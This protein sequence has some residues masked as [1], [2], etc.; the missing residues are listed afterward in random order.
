MEKKDLIL[1]NV[2]ILTLFNAKNV[3][4]LVDFLYMMQ[5]TEEVVYLKIK[6]HL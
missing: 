4:V 3:V 6:G 5:Y 2:I 1:Y